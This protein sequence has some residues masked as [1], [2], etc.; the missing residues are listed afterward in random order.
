M[1]VYEMIV[2]AANMPMT[3][4]TTSNSTI[5][6]ASRRFDDVF[7]ELVFSVFLTLPRRIF[8][9]IKPL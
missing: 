2:I 1:P 7:L 6:K 4:I 9:N 3:T 8:L 5:V